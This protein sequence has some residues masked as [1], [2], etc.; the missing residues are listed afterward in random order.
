[1]NVISRFVDFRLQLVSVSVVMD[2]AVPNAIVEAD[3]L[4]EEKKSE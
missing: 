1:M 3:I 4:I 2:L